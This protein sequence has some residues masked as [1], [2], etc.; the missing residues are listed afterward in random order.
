M[1]NNEVLMRRHYAELS[2]MDTTLQIHKEKWFFPSYI[3][4]DFLKMLLTC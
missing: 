2:L 3:H 4:M 1:P